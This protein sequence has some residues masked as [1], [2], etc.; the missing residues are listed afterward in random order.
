MARRGIWAVVA[1]AA[2]LVV[3]PASA[4]AGFASLY[5]GAVVCTA[6]PAN[7]N[8]RLCTGAPVKTWD[9]RT[10]IDVDVILP[11]LP[12]GTDGPYPLI[13]DFHGWGGERIGLNPQTQ[14]WAE[15]GYAVFSMSD[16]GWGESCGGS[17]PERLPINPACEHGYNH[18][19]DDRY[20]VRDAQ[21]L[22]AVLADEGVAV[23][24]RIGAT[25]A[26]YGGGISIALAALRN[27]TMLADGSLVP[28]VSPGGRPMELAAAVPQWPW[29]DLAY[30]LMPNG[31][32]LDYVADAP[33]RGPDGT[34]PAGIEKTSFVSGLFATGATS[35]N[36]ALPGVDP[37]ADLTF[38]YARINAGEPYDGDPTAES[39]LQQ[40]TTYHSSYYLNHAE[41]PAPLL[42]QSGWNDDLFP[43]DEALR[44]YNRT[45][46][47]YPGDPISLFFMDDGHQ[48]SQNKPADVAVF[49]A[50]LNAWFDH[51]LKGAGP[52]PASSVETLTTTCGTPS[53]GPYTA[54]GWSAIAP[55]EIRLDGAAPQ[56]IA[57]GAGDPTAA[58]S[59]DPIAGSGA[60]A[61]TSGTDQAG[62]ANYRL[63]PAPSGGFTLM[64]S[65][66]VVAEVESTGPESELAARLVDVAPGGT[67]TLVA[68]G[69]YRPTPGKAATVFQ[70]HPQGYRF[71][72]GHVAKLELL[73]A[74]APYART[75]NAQLPITVSN[76]ELRL[77]V[78]EQPG[79]LGGLVGA[80]APKVL[81]PGYEL[82]G[83]Y[84]DGTG[85]G[86]AA[87]RPVAGLSAG[88]AFLAGRLRVRG[89]RLLVPLGCAGAGRCTGRVTVLARSKRGGRRLAG[90]TYSMAPSPSRKP[91]ARHLLRL[92]LTKPGRRLVA[93]RVSTHRG[94]RR[95]RLGAVVRL[96]DAGRPTRLELKRSVRLP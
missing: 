26:S 20:E 30:A 15:R 13:G 70:L 60:C 2:A 48:R 51:Y 54:A 23:P 53:G 36:Y 21:H 38:W 67:E 45:R 40:L 62:V 85:A 11:P 83:E 93:A 82:A 19:M 58:T 52:A 73:P 92:R 10:K 76:L 68:R 14:G 79:S 81:P 89:G 91:K 69:L 50:R 1:V 88:R 27:R 47:Q 32:T 37:E 74:D 18:L 25:G 84:E 29:T 72:T 17:D 87:A 5:G 12:S 71:E 80:P 41:P 34:A 96:D 66:T 77:P 55:G 64:G 35:S 8:V 31:R 46:S 75:S 43:P 24:N 78:V 57:P 56:T 42:I 44:F 7:G 6:Q 16:R 90:G 4:E 49:E 33:Y 28:W 63:A 9:G 65:P 3:A 61:S 95:P 39:I 59:F 22:I 86:G 94:H